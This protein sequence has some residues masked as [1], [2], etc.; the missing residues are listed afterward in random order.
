M[1]NIDSLKDNATISELLD[2]LCEEETVKEKQI[3]SVSE[4]FGLIFSLNPSIFL[5]IYGENNLL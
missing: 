1:R 4:A 2:C 3:I 5:K